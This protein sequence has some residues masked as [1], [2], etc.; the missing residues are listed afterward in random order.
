MYIWIRLV[1]AGSKL[2]LA[3]SPGFHMK[4]IPYDSSVQPDDSDT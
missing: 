4:C 2:T 3:P 1:N